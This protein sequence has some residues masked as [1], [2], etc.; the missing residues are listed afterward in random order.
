MTSSLH[1][2]KPF[3]G[4]E[5][6]YSVSL[7]VDEFLPQEAHLCS[8]FDSYVNHLYVYPLSLKYDSQKIFTKVSKQDG[9]GA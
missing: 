7:E 6:D 5:Y 4:H 1:P 8:T 9:D 2:V 3:L